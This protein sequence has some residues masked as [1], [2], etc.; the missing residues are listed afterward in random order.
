[1]MQTRHPGKLQTLEGPDSMPIARGV[2]THSSEQTLMFSTD[3]LVERC[4][5][6]M[7]IWV[8]H[9]LKLNVFH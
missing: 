5:E 7:I 1:M 9:R 8:A 2:M 6:C 3:V 4:P